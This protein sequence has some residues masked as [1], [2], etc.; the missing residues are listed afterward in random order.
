MAE[1][2]EGTG[3]A[4]R[5]T[6]WKQKPAESDKAKTNQPPIRVALQRGMEL[7]RNQR[8]QE[9][10]QAFREALNQ[11]AF[12]WEV[13]NQCLPFPVHWIGLAFVRSRDFEGHLRLCRQF[14]A[15]E[16]KP[17]DPAGATLRPIILLPADPAPELLNLA[18]NTLPASE[19]VFTNAQLLAWFRF[20]RSLLEYRSGRYAEALASA[21]QATEWRG[22]FCPI[23]GLL[24]QS[25]ACQRLGQ[26][27]EA[28]TLWQRAADS[29]AELRKQPENVTNIRHLLLM[30]LFL[31]EAAALLGQDR[32][33]SLQQG[34]G[35][36]PNTPAP[37]PTPSR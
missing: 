8:W 13:A 37:Q 2:Y 9:A 31:E 36:A 20:H 25:M 12:D 30:E 18:S 3:R 5:A 22:A 11:P 10:A 19:A 33:K 21:R 24:I 27:T 7:S 4:D 17:A 28:R 23:Y 35:A 29:V 26:E 34:A 14:A 32:Q 6:K 16:R 15:V 1:L